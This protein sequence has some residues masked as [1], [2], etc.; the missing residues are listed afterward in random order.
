MCCVL[1]CR[2]FLLQAPQIEAAFN[3]HNDLAR[4]IIALNCTVLCCGALK[5][6]AQ[7][8]TPRVL[9]IPRG[10]RLLRV[11]VNDCAVQM[12]FLADRKVEITDC[13][14]KGRAVASMEQAGGTSIVSHAEF[15]DHAV[16]LVQEM[17]APPQQ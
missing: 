13:K 4:L 17:A 6:V 1:I 9:L 16:R 14:H 12:R 8:G 11:V 7:A 15:Q 10:Q 3:G 5:R 2:S